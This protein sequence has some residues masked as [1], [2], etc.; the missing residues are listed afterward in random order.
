MIVALGSLAGVALLV[1]VAWALGFR[2]T[3]RL[4]ETLARRIAADA[5][6]GFRATTL[7]LADDGRAALLRGA[8]G[9]LLLVLGVG[10]GW[11]TRLVPAAAMARRADRLAIRLPLFPRIEL[12]VPAW[13]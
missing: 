10:D 4:D 1:L 12:P 11:V 5:E 3:P 2:D 6:P 7:A 9:R 8:D 13:L